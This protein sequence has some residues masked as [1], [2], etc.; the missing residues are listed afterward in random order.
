MGKQEVQ[1]ILDAISLGEKLTKVR[2]P[3]RQLA[4]RSAKLLSASVVNPYVKIG[5]GLGTSLVDAGCACLRTHA[6]CAFFEGPGDNKWP[7]SSD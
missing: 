3:A 2:V 4:N 6:T 7:S 5:H 1:D